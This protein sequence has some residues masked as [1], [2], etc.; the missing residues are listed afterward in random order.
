MNV[1]RGKSLEAATALAGINPEVFLFNKLDGQA[2]GFDPLG[3]ATA[4][5]NSSR[6]SSLGGGAP[7]ASSSSAIQT[8]EQAIAIAQQST[9]GQ[10]VQPAQ[11]PVAPSNPFANAL[12]PTIQQQEPPVAQVE[13]PAQEAPKEDTTSGIAKLF[14]PIG[15]AVGKLINSMGED[16]PAAP[17]AVKTATNDG[18]E[19]ESDEED[20]DD[21]DL[22]DIGDDI[23]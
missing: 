23:D 22:D 19:I 12:N 17:K 14:G 18:D 16:Q 4:T 7:G 11:P 1:P 5:L 20:H 9:V 8:P 3:L 15:S 6:P 2:T 13:P 10:I 21:I